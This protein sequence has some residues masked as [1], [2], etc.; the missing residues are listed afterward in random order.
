MSAHGHSKA[1]KPGARSAEVRSASTAWPLD[2]TADDALP[3]P[4]PWDSDVDLSE[5]QTEAALYALQYSDPALALRVCRKAF[6]V[7]EAAG[8]GHAALNALFTAT[9]HARHRSDFAQVDQ[10][11]ALVRQRARSVA[12]S[13]LATRIDQFHAGRLRD[14][15]EFAQAMNTLQNALGTALALGDDR[16]VF[17]VLFNLAIAAADVGDHETAMAL[18]EQQ[19]QFL[20]VDDET[21]SAFRGLRANTA[22]VCLAELAKA[23]QVRGDRLAAAASLREARELALTAVST[24]K[25]DS[26]AVHFLLT[27]VEVFVQ[28][29]EAALARDQLALATAGLQSL[30]VQGTYLRSM[31]LLAEAMIDVHAGDVR[32]QTIDALRAMTDDKVDQASFNH[33]ADAQRTLLAAHEQLGQFEQALACHKR[34]TDWKARN[35]SAVLR[36]RAKVL[37]HSVLAMRAEAVEFVTHDLLTPLAAAQ[38][39]SQALLKQQLPR[40]AV[41]ALRSAQRLLAD[42]TALSGQYLCCLR[43]DLMPRSQLQTLDVG[44]LADD[45][46]ESMGIC[47]A[48]AIDI[49]TPVV[50]DATLLTKA[51]A[52][53]LSEAS[54][55]APTGAGVE[56]GLKHD[57]VKGEAVLS[58]RHEGGDPTTAVRTRLYQRSFDHD[59]FGTVPLGLALAAKVCRLHGMR[60]RFDRSQGRGS[61]LRLTMRTKADSAATSASAAP[62]EFDISLRKKA[63][64]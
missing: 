25:N 48:R 62:A 59:A 52:A 37:R 10:L 20:P 34:C 39:W 45:V 8:D 47:L 53:L 7:A 17:F 6:C 22:A 18:L 11:F 41:P 61:R 44:A 13:S 63:T 60:L 4:A 3:L 15:G 56:L 28:L 24:A 19:A 49:G 46:C 5:Q 57:S 38:T 14:R 55:R 9:T 54:S 51:L 12:R 64:S 32:E 16:T 43:A 31:L 30:P 35:R 29:D 26:Y 21:V 36:Q 33:V 23:Q 1:P 58:I 40:A 50:G 42:A 2:A 27:L